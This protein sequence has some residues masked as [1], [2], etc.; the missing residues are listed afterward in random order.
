MVSIAH[1][2]TSLKRR[3]SRVLGS[4]IEVSWIGS[5]I[6]EPVLGEA[7]SVEQVILDMAARVRAA[8]PYG[9]R[10]VIEMANLELD[11]GCAAAEDLDP[12][13]FVM[14]EMSCLRSSATTDLHELECEMF[15]SLG[16]EWLGTLLPESREILRSLGGNVCEYN[17]P[18]RALTLRAYF[19]SAATVLYSDDAEAS[20][21]TLDSSNTILL[22]EDETYVRE[23]AR[24]ILESA[25]YEVLAAQGAPEAIS[26]LEKHGNIRLLVTDVIMPGMNGLDLSLKLTSMQ[27]KLKTIFMSGYTDNPVLRRDFGTPEVNY[28][29]KP[30]TLETLTEKVRQVLAPPQASDAV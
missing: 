1:C 22:V 29:Q 4:R 5:P 17:E 2:S 14:F 6:L 26:H 9:G 20:L 27:P 23:V 18:G 19:P 25:G 21:S 16:N 13:R 7:E 8:L 30:F 24:E 28:I 11:P 10:V 3:L 12:G 15:D